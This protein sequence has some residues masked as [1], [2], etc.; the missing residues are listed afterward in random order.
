[1]S[2]TRRHE[3][4][5]KGTTSRQDVAKQA[6]LERCCSEIDEAMEQN[7]GRKLYGIVVDMVKDLKGVCPW[8]TRHHEW[9]VCVGVPYGTSLWQV[10]NL[11]EQNGNY[12][13]ALAR[14]KKEFLEKSE[15]CL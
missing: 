10:A 11:K 2:N 8:I 12:K 15:D 4:P 7:Y 6:I 1:M 3:T 14:S 9:Q 13:I 5:T